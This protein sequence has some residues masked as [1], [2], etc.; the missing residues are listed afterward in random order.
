MLTILPHTPHLLFSILIII[1]LNTKLTIAVLARDI[2]DCIKLSFPEK[3]HLKIQFLHKSHVHHIGICMYSNVCI[4]DIHLNKN[5]C[6][7][8]N[9]CWLILGFPTICHYA[10]DTAEKIKIHLYQQ[11]YNLSWCDN[12]IILNKPTTMSMKAS[13][14]ILVCGRC[15]LL[16]RNLHHMLQKLWLN[17]RP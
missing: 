1:E 13:N 7:F 4:F 15:T 11:R 2:D 3:W 17:L 8:A 14:T 10:K 5:Y 12:F 6:H 16:T 9:H